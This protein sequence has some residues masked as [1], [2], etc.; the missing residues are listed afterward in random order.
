M[1]A[2]SARLQ[3]ALKILREKWEITREQW[4]DKNAFDFDKNHIIPLEH[5]VSHALK[6]MDKISEVIAKVRQDCSSPDR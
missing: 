6:G 1:S 2:G 3:H 5:Q 4:T